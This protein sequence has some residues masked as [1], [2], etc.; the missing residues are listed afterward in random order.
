V[1]LLSRQD[2]FQPSPA[3]QP[4]REHS[5]TDCKRLGATR[6]P[7]GKPGGRTTDDWEDAGDFWL[8]FETG[9]RGYWDRQ[10]DEAPTTYGDIPDR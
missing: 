10:P 4:P 5:L 3:R 2:R 7:F 8:I 1:H 9:E 6:S